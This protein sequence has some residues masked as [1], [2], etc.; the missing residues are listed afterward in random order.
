MQD[1]SSTVSA[2]TV[3]SASSRSIAV[4]ISFAGTSMSV[5]ARGPSSAS[6]RTLKRRVNS[7]RQVWGR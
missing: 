3:P 1:V 7:R 2:T 4:R 5:A 6:G